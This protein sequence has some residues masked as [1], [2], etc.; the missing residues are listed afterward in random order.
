MSSSLQF[1]GALL[2]LYLGGASPAF[3]PFRPTEKAHDYVRFADVE[4]H[5]Q[6]VLSSAAGLA[7]DAYRVGDVNR[8]LLSFDKG[9]WHQEASRAPLMPFDG[10]DVRGDGR[11]RLLDPLPLATFAVT[12]V[13]DERCGMKEAVNASGV[14]VLSVS[15]KNRAPDIGRNESVV[16]P[17]FKLSP[18]R[19]KLKIAFE[20]VYTER[21]D[22]ERVLCMVGSAVLP[23]RSTHGADPWDWAMDSGRSSLVPPVM[24]DNNIL[25][26]LRYPKELTLTTRAVLGE[27]T[28]TSAASAATY[29]DPVKL[30][31]QLRYSPYQYRPQELAASDVVGMGNRASKLYNGSYFCEALDHFRYGRGRVL[32]ALPDWH[33]CGN[34]TGAS[35]RSLGPFEM[36]RAAGAYEPAG[37]ISIDD[38]QCRMDDGA[39]GTVRVSAVFQATPPW[40]DP[41]TAVHR[42]GLSGTT[43]S[44]EGA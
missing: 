43:L 5:C 9:D 17:E 2:L 39:A 14:L 28:S 25:L 6:P 13:D 31:S 22:G 3:D 8:D 18:G 36:D 37:V 40:E 33:D 26:V 23:T 41:Y 19:T 27:M 15:R 34:S 44:A 12:H 4:R 32:A 24:A 10:S 29:F 1:L 16:S 30:V 20:G 21:D 11:G 35:C 7:A 38:L 42:W